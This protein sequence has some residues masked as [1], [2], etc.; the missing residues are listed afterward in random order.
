ME[1]NLPKPNFKMVHKAFNNAI[2]EFGADSL[3][4]WL[5]YAKFLIRNQP[6]LV[7][8]LNSVSQ[9]GDYLRLNSNF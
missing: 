3:S 7:G 8:S 1:L 5:E 9:T 2:A 4:C 6:E